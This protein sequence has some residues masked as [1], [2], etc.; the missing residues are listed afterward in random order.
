ARF[1]DTF[2]WPGERLGMAAQRDRLVGGLVG[3]VLEVAVGTGLNLPHYPA[4]VSLDAV[5]IDPHMLR[6]ARRRVP[7]AICEVRLH[8]A[9]VHRLPFRDGTFDHVVVSLALCTI[10][11]PVEALGEMARVIK[12]GGD[13]RLLEHVRSASPGRSRWQGRIAPVWSRVAGGCRIDQDTE[14]VLAAAGYTINDIWR[15]NGGGM[16]QGVARPPA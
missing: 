8:E 14:S 3:R 15:S 13:L 16:I 2:L 12:P 10:P 9:D 1:Y 11:D 5:E 4:T 7:Q 6:R